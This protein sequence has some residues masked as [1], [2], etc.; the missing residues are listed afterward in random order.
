MSE[1]TQPAPTRAEMD[2]VDRGIADALRVY[3]AVPEF[4]R[5]RQDVLLADVWSLPQ[6]TQRDL[7]VVTCTV[8]AVL[9]K[10]DELGAHLRKAIENGVTVEELRGMTVQIA[11]YAGWP[12]G[13]GFGKAAL[14]FL[15]QDKA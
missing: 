14:P 12:A 6:L 13:L 2:P 10:M 11:F 4:S 15:E 1:S 3:A 5:I 7:S 9:G 8:L